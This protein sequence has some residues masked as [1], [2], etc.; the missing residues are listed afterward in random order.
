MLET[1]RRSDV[2]H[3]ANVDLH[4][5]VSL[6]ERVAFD[7]RAAPTSEVLVF[8]SRLSQYLY[9]LPGLSD[10]ILSLKAAWLWMHANDENGCV[11][12]LEP[13]HVRELS[14]IEYAPLLELYLDYF[15]NNSVIRQLKVVERILELHNAD[16]IPASANLL[17]YAI[18]KGILSL[19]IGDH[20]VLVETLAIATK[21]YLKKVEDSDEIYD[22]KV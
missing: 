14:T 4:A 12:L 15:N 10:A 6:A 16:F 13:L 2:I 18:L 19:M 8:F 11:K 17:H 9:C 5:I 1:R 7:M 3:I 21:S 22:L 20:A